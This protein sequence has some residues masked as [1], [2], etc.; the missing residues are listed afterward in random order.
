MTAAY[1]WDA[2]T[3]SQARDLFRAFPRPKPML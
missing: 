2:L 1:V 3:P